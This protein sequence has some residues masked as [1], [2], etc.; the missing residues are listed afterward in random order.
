MTFQD[1]PQDYEELMK[2][3][4]EAKRDLRS[5]GIDVD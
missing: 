2:E 4:D 1:K 5:K 3:I